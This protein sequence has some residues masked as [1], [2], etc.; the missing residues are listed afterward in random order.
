MKKGTGKRS[1]VRD[2]A[3]AGMLSIALVLFLLGLNLK[4][5][6]SGEAVA[7]LFRPG[8]AAAERLAGISRLDGRLVREGGV[9]V[10]DV[11]V[12]S[13]D[14]GLLDLWKIGVLV[15]IDPLAARGCGLVST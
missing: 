11:A 13:R 2:L 9:E 5:P 6:A 7:L 8:T 14:I 12:F 3:P 4:L 10:V 1:G 15:S